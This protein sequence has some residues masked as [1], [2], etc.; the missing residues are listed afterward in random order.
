MQHMLTQVEEGGRMHF[1]AFAREMQ[2]A[3]ARAMS[4]VLP[5]GHQPPPAARGAGTVS[6][7]RPSPA[8]QGRTYDCACACLPAA[9]CAAGAVRAFASLPPRHPGAARTS[10]PRLRLWEHAVTA[11]GAS[12]APCA[13]RLAA[14]RPQRAPASTHAA[15]P[16]ARHVIVARPSHR[17][18]IVPVR[19]APG[20]RLRP[21]RVSR[22]TAHHAHIVA[23]QGLHRQAVLGS[24]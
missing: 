4:A 9:R 10:S 18:H 17:L 13:R 7:A 12:L 6:A 14:P 5:R 19:C 11:R 23:S 15:R 21:D 1:C 3:R 2:L 22:P 16:P 24:L 8:R 20:F